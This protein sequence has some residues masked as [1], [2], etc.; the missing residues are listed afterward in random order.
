MNYNQ[1]HL[2]NQLD[3]LH[4]YPLYLNT[5]STLYEYFNAA[6][7]SETYEDLEGTIQRLVVGEEIPEL[8]GVKNMINEIVYA[9][10]GEFDVP[11]AYYE[12]FKSRN[13][14]YAK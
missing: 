5:N 3:Y 13:L 9:G 11:M 1:D 4:H 2:G 6:Y 12:H 8:P 7:C 10:K 14:N